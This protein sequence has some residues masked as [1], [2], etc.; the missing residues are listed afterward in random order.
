MPWQSDNGIA[1]KAYSYLRFST[2]EQAQGD[3][4]RRQTVLAEAYARQHG[5]ELDTTLRFADE[6]VSAFRGKNAATGALSRFISAVQVG[7]IEEGSYLLV[8]SLDRISRN[9]VTHAQGLFLQLIGLGITLVTLQDGKVYSND[10]INANPVDLIVSLLVMIRAH[11]ESAT[12]SKRLKQAWVGKR[13]RV[14]AGTA[15]L[16]SKAPGWLRVVDGAE[17]GGARCFEVIE[18]RADVVRRVFALTLKGQ[19]KESIARGL[20]EEG[21]PPFG[22]AAQW[23]PSYVQKV[24]TNPA[25]IGTL[26]TGTLE[27]VDGRAQRQRLGTVPDYYPA[28]VDVETFNR[29]QALKTTSTKTKGRAPVQNVLAGLAVCPLCGARMTRVMKGTGAK[30]GKPY[31]VC[32]KAKGGAGCT[33]KAVHLDNVEAAVRSAYPDIS[34]ALTSYGFEGAASDLARLE[35]NELAL[36]DQI[37]EVV[38]AIADLGKSNALTRRLRELETGLAALQADIKAKRSTM[39]TRSLAARLTDLKGAVDGEAGTLNTAMRE[40]FASVVVEYR[41]GELEMHAHSGAVL[42]VTYQWPEERHS[43]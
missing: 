14:A 25:V 12:K 32:S 21:V 23:H 41:A 42:R 2:P 43:A 30:A 22:R 20:T 28:I 39:G 10:A 11:E 40:L 38:S 33:Y 26:A 24:L 27:H 6:G 29:V 19:G 17:G 9:A 18:D 4:F 37:E 15:I 8:E 16:T 5:L 34:Q 36:V 3:S 31:L 7:E 13:E 1:L 35:G